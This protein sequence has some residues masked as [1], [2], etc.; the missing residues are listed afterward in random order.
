MIQQHQSTSSV[1]SDDSILAIGCS[2][3]RVARMLQNETACIDGLQDY[4]WHRCMN[5]TDY[6]A[7]P[8]LCEGR[9]LAY[10]CIAEGGELWGGEE[11]NP[12]FEIRCAAEIK[13]STDGDGGGHGDHNGHSHGSSDDEDSG[14]L[15]LSIAAAAIFSAVAAMLV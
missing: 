2:S 11:H 3:T 14:T 13:N 4:C 6:D 8:A 9:N 1:E 7:S 12:I 15:Q 10:G 5:Y